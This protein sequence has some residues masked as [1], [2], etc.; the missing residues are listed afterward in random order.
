[1]SEGPLNFPAAQAAAAP[2]DAAAPS[3]TAAQQRRLRKTWR[4]WSPRPR[5]GARGWRAVDRAHR[6]QIA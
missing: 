3:S 2:A 5:C 1:M 6:Q 4:R